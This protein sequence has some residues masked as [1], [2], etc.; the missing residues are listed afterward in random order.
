M[1]SDSGN[2][3]TIKLLKDWLVKNN[4]PHDVRLKKRDSLTPNADKLDSILQDPYFKK[5]MF[6]M[7]KEFKMNDPEL[8][9]TVLP[10]M[11]KE[12]LEHHG[13]PEILR[14]PTKLRVEMRT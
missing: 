6:M 7:I 11:L 2:K 8:I 5:V 14:D 9:T 10:M 3:Q 12:I 1:A 13:G 4:L